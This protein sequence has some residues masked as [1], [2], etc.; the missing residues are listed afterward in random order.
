MTQQL[1]ISAACPECDAPVEFSRQ[2]LN[3]QIVNCTQCTV[4]LEVTCRS[5]IA[6]EVAPEVEE[7]WGE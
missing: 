1:I 3:G 7:D 4:E 5:P 6:L 2:P